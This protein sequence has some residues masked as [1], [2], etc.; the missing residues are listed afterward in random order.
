M[1]GRVDVL[2]SHSIAPANIHVPLQP[3]EKQLN[4]PV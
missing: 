3:G 4:R 2:Q 1:N